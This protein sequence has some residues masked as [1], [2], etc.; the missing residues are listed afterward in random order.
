MSDQSKYGAATVGFG[1]VGQKELQI[2]DYVRS[3]Y[4][5]NRI[6]SCSKLEDGSYIISVENIESSGRNVSN[7]M[8]LS[9]E[10]LVGLISNC[11]LYFQI[12]NLDVVQMINIAT[13]GKEINYSI[14]DNL[15][16]LNNE[17]KP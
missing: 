3:N 10:S 6:M 8:W 16:P 17:K 7:K 15:Q 4:T 5:D 14:S 2:V 11:L 13:D 1:G 9:E 12:K